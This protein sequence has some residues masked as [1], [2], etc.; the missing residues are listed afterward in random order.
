M[1][2]PEPMPSRLVRGCIALAFTAC[3]LAVACS[4]GLADAVKGGKLSYMALTLQREP[5]AFRSLLAR[6]RAVLAD[7]ESMLSRL[8]RGCIALA[9]TACVLAVACS[10][11]PADAIKFSELSYMALAMEREPTA[12]RSLLMRLGAVLADP[13][14]MLAR[15]ARGWIALAFTACVPADQSSHRL[16]DVVKERRTHLHASSDGTRANRVQLATDTS[17]GGPGRP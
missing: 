8:A 14:P 10:H 4:H 12:Y 1:A 6:A 11:R 5:T 16:A 7:P 17:G 2:D 15:L 3:V 13:E 9:F